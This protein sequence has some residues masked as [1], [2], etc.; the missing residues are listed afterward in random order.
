[1]WEIKVSRIKIVFI[2]IFIII[3]FFSILFFSGFIRDFSKTKIEKIIPPNIVKKQVVYVGVVSRFAP[4]LIYKGYQPIMDYLTENTNYD[5]QLKL[6][7]SYEETI[8]DLISKKIDI[9]F[10][11]TYI[12]LN[13]YENKNIIPILAPKNSEGLPFSNVVLISKKQHKISEICSLKNSKIALPSKQ[14]FASNWFLNSFKD[15]CG[16]LKKNKIEIKH[17]NYHTSVIFQVLKGKYD[18]GVVK[19][20]IADEFTNRGLELLLKSEKIPASPIVTRVDLDKSLVEEFVKNMLDI[21]KHNTKIL[22]KFDKEF[23]NGFAKVDVSDYVKFKN[24]NKDKY[25]EK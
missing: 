12:Y 25:F 23:S 10:I 11:G 7:N 2:A 20:S 22:E 21:E 14:S 5:F 9:G 8:N 16:D 3:L 18:F 13:G 6:S 15:N 1:M 19:K 24:R 4:P 17:F